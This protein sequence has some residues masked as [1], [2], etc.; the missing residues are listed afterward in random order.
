MTGTRTVLVVDDNLDFAEDVQEILQT[1]SIEVDI[2]G[3]GAEA[4]ELLQVKKYDL[5]LTNMRM[6]E[7][8]GLDVARQVKARTPDVPVVLMTGYADEAALTCARQAGAILCMF[9]PLNFERLIPVLHDLISRRR[10]SPQRLD[11]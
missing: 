9:K 7:V 5:V 6:P 2:A 4:L 1:E 8:G 3:H 11:G 10:G